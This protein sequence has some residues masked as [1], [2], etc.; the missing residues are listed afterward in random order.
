VRLA[1]GARVAD[2][3]ARA[4]GTTRRADRS[5]VN[6][7]APVSDG[8]QVLVPVRGATPGSAAPAVGATAGPLSLSTA[9]A[10]QLDALPGVGPVTAQKIL[11]Y[12]SQHGAFHDVAELDA[13][14][15]IGPARLADL[16]GLVVP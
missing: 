12:R 16:N 5:G 7:A 1:S 6:F 8:Q 4:G 10:E 3:V 11:A 15:G 2:A 14:P 9:T 13:I